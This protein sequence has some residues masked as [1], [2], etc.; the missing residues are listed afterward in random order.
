MK[1]INAHPRRSMLR[2]AIT[3]HLSMRCILHVEQLPMSPL[4]PST[5]HH[6]SL[7]A[8]HSV[9]QSSLQLFWKTMG[10]FRRMEGV[11]DWKPQP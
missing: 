4:K 6:G 9:T 11:E 2:M 7:Q 3:V 1:E 5:Q 10:G 8:K